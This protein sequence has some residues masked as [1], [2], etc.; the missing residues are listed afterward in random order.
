MYIHT[1]TTEEEAINFRG[2]NSKREYFEGK[3]KGRSATVLLY[4]NLNIKKIES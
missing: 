2:Q 4:S 1:I 3:M